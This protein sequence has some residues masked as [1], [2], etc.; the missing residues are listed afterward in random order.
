MPTLSSR[1]G[2][3]QNT[4]HRTF[5]GAGEDMTSRSQQRNMKYGSLIDEP[6]TYY[7]E[8]MEATLKQIWGRRFM[9][10]SVR[11]L[12]TEKDDLSPQRMSHSKKWS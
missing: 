11:T 12:E 1:T 2:L 3:A 7:G 4:E 8:V 5:N 9:D 6:F 10:N